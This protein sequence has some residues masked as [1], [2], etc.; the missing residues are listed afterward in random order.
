MNTRATVYF[1]EDWSL[2]AVFV[3]L[4]NHDANPAYWTDA[5]IVEVD[6]L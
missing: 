6:F 4:A 5:R 2:T 3:W 1:P